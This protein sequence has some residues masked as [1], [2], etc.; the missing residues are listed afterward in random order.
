MS[1]VTMATFGHPWTLMGFHG[2]PWVSPGLPRISNGPLRVSMASHG[3]PW[4]SRGLPWGS[5]DFNGCAIGHTWVFR[6]LPSSSM[7]PM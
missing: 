5:I 6:G 3:L 1:M 2:L 4:I 7:G